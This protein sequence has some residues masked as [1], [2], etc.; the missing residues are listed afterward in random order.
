MKRAT[1][2]LGILL[3]STALLLPGV[4]HAGITPIDPL[5]LHDRFAI[6]V[7]GGSVAL[8]SFEYF[9]NAGELAYTTLRNAGYDED[10]IL[11]LS[12]EIPAQR[13]A[14]QNAVDMK[15]TRQNINTAFN[16]LVTNKLASLPSPEQTAEI[17]VYFVGPAEK[18]QPSPPHG[19]GCYH[20]PGDIVFPGVPGSPPI[21]PPYTGG[22]AEA[23][24]DEGGGRTW[25]PWGGFSIVLRPT[26]VYELNPYK[27][28]FDVNDDG[29]YQDPFPEH[30]TDS[31]IRP[32]VRRLRGLFKQLVFVMDTD[33]SLWVGDDVIISGS[34]NEGK[35]FISSTDKK[36]TNAMPYRN[37]TSYPVRTEICGTLFGYAFFTNL[38]IGSTVE[39][40]FD[41]ARI[42]VNTHTSPAQNPN[43]IDRA[44]K[45]QHGRDVSVGFH[46]AMDPAKKAVIVV[47]TDGT[48]PWGEYTHISIDN[49]GRYMATLLKD[50][51]YDVDYF[52]WQAWSEPGYQG[53][54]YQGPADMNSLNSFLAG[55][56][57][58]PNDQVVFYFTSHGYFDGYN[59]Q[60]QGNGPAH[61]IPDSFF[62]SH[63]DA[64]L[65][66]HDN[67]AC[68]IV[69]ACESGCLADP[70]YFNGFT[71]PDR[72]VL[73]A[74][75]LY[76][77]PSVPPYWLSS[78]YSWWYEWG[79]L[80]PPMGIF[81]HYLVYELFHNGAVVETA[82]PVVDQQTWDEVERLAGLGHTSGNERQTPAMDDQLPGD[83]DL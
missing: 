80:G 48:D 32:L 4:T 74:P 2:T 60:F 50:S 51:G 29:D 37:Y 34:D 25:G 81:T 67:P 14:M 20:G 8:S 3:I 27:F 21:L 52:S 44:P 40:A 9:R 79:C 47:G 73:T 64:I 78:S 19:G 12:P 36:R 39:S 68:I 24:V 54:T 72:V 59:W 57:L 35:I 76:T 31:Q 70:T 30:I 62:R 77:P 45:Y 82:F 65:G 56:T 42:D 71:G 46:T 5:P 6:I 13:E 69:E 38:Q 26:S 22:V 66:V 49:T 18:E 75:I 10:D 7:V 58:A 83:F 17:F 53:M 41:T 28:L 63:V 1:S 55:Y 43:I 61:L 16:T 15:T 33:Y 11:Y 23:G